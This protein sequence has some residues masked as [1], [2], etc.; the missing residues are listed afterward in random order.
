MNHRSD[1]L[2]ARQAFQLLTQ[3]VRTMN[4]HAIPDC[5]FG[6]TAAHAPSFPR[7]YTLLYIRPL[8]LL[9]PSL[10]DLRPLLMPMSPCH[11]K[12]PDL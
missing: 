12:G 3:A 6:V 7:S 2:I 1:I 9:K 4:V 11:D 5:P 10:K 8:D